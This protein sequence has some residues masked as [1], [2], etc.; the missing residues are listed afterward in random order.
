MRDPLQCAA[1]A[2]YSTDKQNPLSI[3]DQIAK[4][5]EFA[6]TRG[7]NLL[8]S[9]I[10]ADEEVS[11]ATLARLGLKKL[12]TAAESPARPFGVLLCED[13][14]RLSR[15]TA[16]ILNLCERLNFAG[17]RVVF[18]AQGIDSADETF[19]LL[20]HARG[21][22]DQLFL[23][24]TAK[25]VHRGM[26]GLVSRQ[27][28]TGGRVFGYRSRRDDDGVRLEVDPEQAGAV[29]RIFA[30]YA[31]GDSLKVI[32]KRL[33]SERVPPPA[34]YRGQRHASWSPA[35][36]S[37][38]LHNERYSGTVVW[39][40]TQKLRDPQTG[41]RIQRLRPR[42]EWRI[43]EAP[44]LRIVP[45]ELWSEVQ[46]RIAAVRAAFTPDRREGLCSRAYSARY[47]L[48]GFVKCGLCGSNLV[49]V[50]GSGRG[51]ASRD[52]YGC[53]LHHHR[54]VCDSTLLVR[55]DTLER[56]ILSGLQREVLR[57]EVAAY[58]VEEFKR[59][60]R[61]RL[62]S[63]R[64]QVAATRRR[65]EDLR[66]QIANIVKIIAEGHSSPTLLAELAKREK[67]LEALNDELLAADNQ[68]LD[69][70]L[71]EIDAFVRRRLQDV[72]STLLAD[73]SRA[74]VELAKHCAAIHV[75]PEGDTYRINGDWDLLGG[76]SVGAG[77]RNRTAYAGLFRAALYQ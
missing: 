18:I 40:R 31:A 1:Y 38:I 3:S 37:V 49:L 75:T 55:R 14:S 29:R 53:P 42:S 66:Y 56:E 30:D 45:D 74:K 6:A 41:R 68:G 63:M 36:L 73:V 70:K 77:G 52:K 35:A 34:P 32:A 19:Q 43:M 23:A 57:E 20:L 25:R 71:Q 47:L 10:F 22:I 48:S 28:H 39:N 4:C 13:S 50:A 24:D 12:L 7:W 17:V 59:Q 54:G 46:A 72:R 64:G 58:A 11:G 2:R 5:K 67:E 69:A 26:S 8:D 51:H 65:R 27:L 16:D 21:M 15:K 33:N 9:C 76:R 44:E 61:E 62:E 60:L